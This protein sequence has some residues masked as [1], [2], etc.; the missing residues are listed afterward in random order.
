MGKR[1]TFWIIAIVVFLLDRITKFFILKNIQLGESINFKLFSITHVLNTGTL[2][3]MFK[4]VSWFFITFAIIVSIYLI[5][6]H[7]TFENK[8]QPFLGLILAGALGNLYDRIFYGAVIDFI[9]FHFWPVFNVADSAIVIAVFGLLLH[10][11]VLTKHN[12]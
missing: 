8:V 9:D 3:G 10:E 2:F 12:I 4:N 5:L 1:L 6:K 11:Y 7:S